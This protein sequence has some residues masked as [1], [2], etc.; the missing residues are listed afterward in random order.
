MKETQLTDSELEMVMSCREKNHIDKECNIELSADM[1]R[2]FR[3]GESK[4]PLSVFREDDNICF[5]EVKQR[6]CPKRLLTQEEYNAFPDECKVTKGIFKQA[7]LN[8]ALF[9]IIG[10]VLLY[11]SVLN[12]ASAEDLSESKGIFF[13]FGLSF[14]FLTIFSVMFST[15]RDHMEIRQVFKDTEAVFGK[16]LF[17]RKKPAQSDVYGS[18]EDYCIDVVFYDNETYIKNISCPKDIWEKLERED[19]VCLLNGRLALYRENG[20]L[21]YIKD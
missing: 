9:L 21:V 8:S 11:F 19:E 15:Y 2:F 16:V 13:L 17:F 6:R 7:F 4:Q 14:G 20:K 18:C 10:L 5:E 3:N 12:I 1:R